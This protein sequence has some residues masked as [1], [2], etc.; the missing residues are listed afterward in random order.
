MK[1]PHTRRVQLEGV[2][3]VVDLA[4]LGAHSEEL[5]DEVLHADETVLAQ[6]LPTHA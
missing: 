4:E 5:V 6:V 3:E 1:T 2:Q